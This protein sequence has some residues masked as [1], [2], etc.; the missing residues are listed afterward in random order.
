MTIGSR[1]FWIE[2]LSLPRKADE[3]FILLCNRK[4]YPASLREAVWVGRGQSIYSSLPKGGRMGSK[5][6]KMF[7][8]SRREVVWIPAVA[9]ECFNWFA[10]NLR[11]SAKGSAAI[12]GKSTMF[13]RA[14]SNSGSFHRNERHESAKIATIR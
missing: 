6:R 12:C 2:V 9:T 4:D 1:D 13:F 7:V 8:T 5:R 14:V 10:F 11:K 3:F